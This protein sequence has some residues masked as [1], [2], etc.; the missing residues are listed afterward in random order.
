MSTLVE[1]C[2]PILINVGPNRRMLSFSHLARVFL[3]KVFFSSVIPPKKYIFESNIKNSL[4]AEILQT[5]IK[6]LHDSKVIYILIQSIN[7]IDV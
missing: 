5:S 2:W 3:L 4:N 1:N 6:A 7:K